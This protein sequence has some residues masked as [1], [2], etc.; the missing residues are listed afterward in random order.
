LTHFHFSLSLASFVALRLYLSF[1]FAALRQPVSSSVWK[2][3]S[4]Y[5]TVTIANAP[6]AA[7]LRPLQASVVIDT[8]FIPPFAYVV[9]SASAN[10]R[11]VC[12]GPQVH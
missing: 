11:V 10:S 5:V 6:S 7:A 2:P 12:A 4:A 1:D 3:G 8:A 9:V